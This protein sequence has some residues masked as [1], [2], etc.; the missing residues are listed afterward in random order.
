MVEVEPFRLQAILFDAD[1]TLFPTT[2]Y[3]KRAWR[4]GREDLKDALESEDRMVSSKRI[5][6]AHSQVLHEKGSDNK[7]QFEDLVTKIGIEKHLNAKFASAA[8]VGYRQITPS[9]KPYPRAT[10][11]LKRLG[12][13]LGYRIYGVSKG[14]G[15][16]QWIKL[17]LSGL[18]NLLD[19]AFVTGCYG[20]NEKSEEFYKKVL[21]NTGLDG[22]YCLMIGDNIDRD[23]NPARKCGIHTARVLTGKYKKG[24]AGEEADYVI[25][26]LRGVFGVIKKI[27]K[28][29]NDKLKTAIDNLVK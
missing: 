8:V 5:K 21:E 25:R 13:K 15:M 20:Y 26:G 7:H 23:I 16:N 2:D 6:K 14:D 1:D 18:T 10:S 11:T 29:E 27:E 9:L 12:R 19:D 17:R 3:S 28:A 24:K 4:Q 22:R